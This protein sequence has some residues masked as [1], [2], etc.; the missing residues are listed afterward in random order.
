MREVID[1]LDADEELPAGQGQPNERARANLGMQDDESVYVVE[2]PFMGIYKGNV[3]ARDETQ[4][5][6]TAEKFV[7]DSGDMVDI[8]CGW[9]EKIEIG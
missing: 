2:I 5:I 1:N 7:R 9:V 3:I 4:A 6:A 8:C